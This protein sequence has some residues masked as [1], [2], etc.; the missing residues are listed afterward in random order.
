MVKEITP[1]EAKRHLHQ[2][3]EIA[4]FDVRDAGP[5]SMGHPLFAVPLPLRDLAEKVGALAPRKT[6]PVL[7]IDDDGSACAT[8]ARLLETMGY[9]YVR[10]LAGG[11]AAWQAAG[12]TLFQGVHVPS[13]TLGELAEVVSH[14]KTVT[15]ETLL[16]WQTEKRDFH[17]F[18]CRPPA[19][20][21]EMTVP[22]ARCVPNGEIA[23]RLPAIGD[24]KPIV[25]TC[26][27][28]TRGLIGAV[29]LS[30]VAD[31]DV[32]ALEDGTQ[33]WVLAGF[34]LARDNELEEFPTLSPMQAQQ[35]HAVAQR[36]LAD[37]S[38]AT[39][40]AKD[41]A[42]YL[43]D[44]TRTTFLIDVRSDD[45]FGNDPLP[46]FDHALS[47]QLVQATDKWIGV[48]RA[49]VILGDDLGLRAA[50]AAWWLRMMGFET[51][52]VLID[53]TLRSVDLQQVTTEQLPTS[54]PDFETQ[55][56]SGNGLPAHVTWFA[57]GRHQGNRDASRLY[58]SW[59]KGLVA[60]LDDQERA[61]FLL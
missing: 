41:V 52:V 23:H 25:L 37:Q 16:D 12:Y 34:E 48:R 13:K 4:F 59:E 60:Q 50:I 24:D 1:A 57:H 17:F 2:D 44:E 11:V 56:D 22:G 58:L 10:V 39:I 9:G 32:Y 3:G 55:E 53:D 46:G 6:V 45:E 33:G 40:N 38:I 47:G 61:E 7:L 8:A 35:T 30:M 27:G 20:F 21:R 14:P 29:S 54:R 19:E 26:A 42:R 15:P 28:R 31:R 49:R 51:F 5:F 36:V 18:D 43:Q